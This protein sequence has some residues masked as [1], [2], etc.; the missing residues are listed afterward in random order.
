MIPVLH[1]AEPDVI[2]DILVKDFTTFSNKQFYT[3]YFGDPIMDYSMDVLHD[4]QWKRARA[5]A[6]PAFSSAKLK[7][8]F[9]LMDDCVTQ[10]LNA[11]KN[12]TDK[13]NQISEWDL[14]SLF[15]NL[16]MSV[17]ARCG[18][19]IELDT[20]ADKQH[21][22]VTNAA[23]MLSLSTLQSIIYYMGPLAM[24]LTGIT[25]CDRKASQWFVQMSKHIISRRKEE[26]GQKDK[27]ANK[28]DA[29]FLQLMIEAQ[30]KYE[31]AQKNG[32]VTNQEAEDIP[33]PMTEKEL[34]AQ[35]SVFLFVGYETT[36]MTLMW[37]AY[38]LARNPKEQ[39]LLLQEIRSQLNITDSE[40][41][42]ENLDLATVYEYLPKLVR[43]QATIDEVLRLHTP[44]NRLVVRRANS[45][46]QIA[47]SSLKRN[48]AIP[49]ATIVRIP[50]AALHLN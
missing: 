32:N 17:A 14:K 42:G 12:K 21:P 16:A 48:I 24:N 20:F 35:C 6:T 15:S 5:A 8:M 50:L 34:V 30:L 2:R 31:N 27:C 40:P 9:Y 19:G 47:S 7:R 26:M 23:K 43:L 25:I 45:S 36:S 33:E 22:F 18:F 49:K 11:V 29:D 3:G 37:L 1:V 4:A 46:Y 28:S 10:M 41:E 38:C 44:A 13:T 39:D